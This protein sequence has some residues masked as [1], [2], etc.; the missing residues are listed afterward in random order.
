MKVEF[1]DHVAY[2][3]LASPASQHPPLWPL[4]AGLLGKV[5]RTDNTFLML[6]LLTEAIG[7]GLMVVVV[8]AGTRRKR[9]IVTI[10]ALAFVA[11]AMGRP[12]RCHW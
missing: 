12:F 6:K 3:T 10:A 9:P 8:Y 7:I 1:S 5:L 2:K 11:L 4:A